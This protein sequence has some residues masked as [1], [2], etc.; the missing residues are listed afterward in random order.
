M[1]CVE[2]RTGPDS[3]TMEMFGN[4]VKTGAEFKMMAMELKRDS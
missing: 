1:R 2:K 4:D 3:M